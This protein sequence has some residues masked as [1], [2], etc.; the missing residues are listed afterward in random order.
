M[1]QARGAKN[2]DETGYYHLS[3]AGHMTLRLRSFRLMVT[4]GAEPRRSL[5]RHGT[6]LAFTLASFAV[7]PHLTRNPGDQSSDDAG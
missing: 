5:R 1:D 4:S 6:A 2:W 7:E 3:A